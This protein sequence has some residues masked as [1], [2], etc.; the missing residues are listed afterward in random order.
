LESDID[1]ETVKVGNP[2]GMDDEP[3][4][5]LDAEGFETMMH[6]LME[7]YHKQKALGN[8]KFMKAFIA[9]NSKN[10]MLMDDLQRLKSQ[11][12]MPLTW[13]RHKH[14]ATMYYR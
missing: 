2:V 13:T 10:Q 6:S 3:E 11:R 4:S 8:I 1:Q 7:E 5:E 9:G 14:P 12:T